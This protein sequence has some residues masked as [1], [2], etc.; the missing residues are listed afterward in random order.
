MQPTAA[1]PVPTA[2]PPAAQTAQLAASSVSVTSTAVR[3]QAFAR[4][5]ALA[6]GAIQRYGT[7]PSASA[8]MSQAVAVLQSEL[9]Q[10]AEDA[11]RLTAI[12]TQAELI[13]NRE[14]LEILY[15]PG[16]WQDTLEKAVVFASAPL[17]E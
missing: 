14:D 16:S 2:A 10:N 8:R 9:K 4:A 3:G 13:L 11:A 15:P 6:H 7:D 12:L 17:E 5:R 1:A